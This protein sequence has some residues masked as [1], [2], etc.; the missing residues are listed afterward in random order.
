MKRPISRKIHLNQQKMTLRT[1][2]LI[3]RSSGWLKHKHFTSVV[4]FCALSQAFEAAGTL[5][6]FFS[7][8]SNLCVHSIYIRTKGRTI[9]WPFDLQA[10]SSVPVQRPNPYLLTFETNTY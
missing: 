6:V 7:G 9:G 4:P 3:D 8:S 5:A 1:V 10:G 2:Q